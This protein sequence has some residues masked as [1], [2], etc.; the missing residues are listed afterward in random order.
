MRTHHPPP[1]FN[2]DKKSLRKVEIVDFI[3][4]NFPKAFI[5]SKSTLEQLRQISKKLIGS[6]NEAEVSKSDSD[7]RSPSESEIL[8]KANTNENSKLNSDA[9]TLADST[10]R[11][12]MPRS[13]RS[14]ISSKNKESVASSPKS[15]IAPTTPSKA[16]KREA[17]VSLS[18]KRGR[19]PTTTSKTSQKRDYT[20]S[21]SPKRGRSPTTPSKASRR[22]EFS[23]S[24]S[25]RRGRS[26]TTPSKASRGREF[27]SS[28]SP[29]QGRS[30]TTPSK[31]SRR[32][33]FSSSPSPRRGRSP[34]TP[35]K[36]S[37]RRE[38]S[39]SP[40]PRRGRSSQTL[41]K[42]IR[43][44]KHTASHSP[45]RMHS[46]KTQSKS[47]RLQ[48]TKLERIKA[49]KSTSH[50][51]TLPSS[52]QPHRKKKSKSH[53]LVQDL[54][55]DSET[56]SENSSNSG[57]L[58]NQSSTTG[59]SVI[60]SSS[61]SSTFTPPDNSD[62]DTGPVEKLTAV[63]RS[64]KNSKNYTSSENKKGG[65]FSKKHK[66]RVTFSETS[67]SLKTN[68]KPY[69]NGYDSGYAHAYI[70]DPNPTLGSTRAD[71]YNEKI[72]VGDQLDDVE[73]GSPLPTFPRKNLGIHF[74]S[75]DSS[76]ELNTRPAREKSK[77]PRSRRK[78]REYPPIDTLGSFVPRD[79]NSFFTPA[80]LSHHSN[81]PYQ[82][83]YPN[84]THY[85]PN[86]FANIR[87]QGDRHPV[88]D[89]DS[90]NNFK[91]S[92]V[93]FYTTAPNMN[94]PSTSSHTAYWE[95]NREGDFSGTAWNYHPQG[96][97]ASAPSV[98]TQ[99]AN[100]QYLN[101]N[102]SY[103]PFDYKY[104]EQPLTNS[105][106][107]VIDSSKTFSAN[108]EDD[109]WKESQKKIKDI[110]SPA[111]QSATTKESLPLLS[112]GTI[113]QTKITEGPLALESP[114]KLS[115]E[116]NHLSTKAGNSCLRIQANPSKENPPATIAADSSLSQPSKQES[117]ITHAL[118]KE[119][120]EIKKAS[121]VDT[122]KK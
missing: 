5:P 78:K 105:D 23:S 18:T 36:A 81:N 113:P 41:S 29:R 90:S 87:G 72:K 71:Y 89:Q 73:K 101:H 44:R 56:E 55:S 14:G 76:L 13:R 3:R 68:Q 118:I 31:A 37:R 77:S 34:T 99:P 12:H 115:E 91:Y 111:P 49:R 107:S 102:S 106:K 69:R 65:R 95:P 20:A 21:P 60:S 24:P 17:P 52:S 58:S 120:D 86:T 15:W 27:S 45:K 7:T 22:R 11:G 67:P 116:N 30:P 74:S 80:A 38:F 122:L 16:R 42:S 114:V 84:Q 6:S 88:P 109:N 33:E 62:Y 35:S 9:A 94:N 98:L 10:S 8:T 117:G 110:S 108:K 119:L 4:V 97:H 82:P 51:K 53:N 48:D 85:S 112:E 59:E 1:R 43:K 100:N 83:L 61:L 28:P 25:P 50:S 39:S 93:A 57:S 79:C 103:T 70:T 46:T 54:V 75:P 40:S 64:R 66:R 92:P 96:Q 63:Q 121:L 26:P 19:S 104:Q 32:R 2:P 47:S